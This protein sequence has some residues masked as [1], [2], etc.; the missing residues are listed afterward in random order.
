VA[1][2]T[3]ARVLADSVSSDGVRLTT[4][5]VTFPRFILAEFNTHR[6]FS[7][8]SASSRAIP[9]ARQVARVQAEPF[10]PRRFPVN[11]PGMSATE[12]ID[13]VT[14]AARYFQCQEQWLVARD[15]ALASAELMLAQGVHKQI[16]N[17]LLEPFMW[18]TAIVSSTE[19]SNFFDLR[20]S[21]HAQPEI[22]T[23]A[24]A[25]RD[26]LR[27]SAPR[28]AVWHL[29][30]VEP[31]EQDLPL[32]EQIVSSV[33]RVAA[34]SYDRHTVR[35]YAAEFKRFQKLADSRHLSPFEHVAHAAYI[36][37][38]NFKGWKQVRWYVE[39]DLPLDKLSGQVL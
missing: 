31:E 11:R 27:S 37:S 3:S 6:V 20:I 13:E 16:A 39:H 29:P 4:L 33:A 9:V 8:N 14:D 34:V 24:V 32:Y 1:D 38:A 2:L 10:V 21:E 19:W 15:A 7:R 23:T 5:E 22:Y 18:H 12:Y 25:M 36:G 30:L 28:S 35:D 17:R 26:A